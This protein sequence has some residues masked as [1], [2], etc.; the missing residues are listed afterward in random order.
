MQF[1]HADIKYCFSNCFFASPEAFGQFFLAE[2]IQ[3]FTI[4][5]LTLLPLCI[6]IY[7]VFWVW[8]SL[9]A[10]LNGVQEA[11]GSNPLTQTKGKSLNH[12]VYRDFL[13]PILG[14]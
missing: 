4:L 11:G 2:K 13:L 7:G 8:R 14:V 3:V 1:S 10:C 6:I 5:A 12:A 9:V